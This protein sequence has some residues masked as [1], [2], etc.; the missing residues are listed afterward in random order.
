[1]LGRRDSR[2][3]RLQ[4]RSQRGDDRDQGRPG[5]PG[6]RRGAPTV[7]VLLDG[8]SVT[9]D[10]IVAVSRQDA[11]VEL[12][13]RAIDRTRPSRRGLEQSAARGEPIYGYTTAVGAQK[14]VAL[15]GADIQQFNRMMVLNCRLGQGPPVGR[16]VV[17]A[18]LLRLANN[19]ARAVVGVRPEL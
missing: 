10:D 6:R 17:R 11:K 2:G 8:R 5:L 9:L 14:R 4:G 19:L 18:T 16:D 7:T 1:G 12:A 15:E 13:P 3:S